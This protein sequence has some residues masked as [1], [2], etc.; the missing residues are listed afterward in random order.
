MAETLEKYIRRY[1]KE[2]ERLSKQKLVGSIKKDF[3][4][5][6]DN[7]I[8]MYLSKLKKE[9]VI[10]APSRGIYEMDSYIPFQPNISNGLKRIFNKVKREFPYINFCIW[11]T[12]WLNDFMLHQP[13]K[14]Y[15]VIEV[16]KGASESVFAFLTETN[17]NVF[18][19]PDEEIFDR[20]IHNQD[21]V[22]IVKNMVSES[23]LIEK[24][25]INVPALEKLLVDMLIDTT[26]FSAQQNEKEFI[27]RSVMQKY[28]LNDLKMRRYAVRRNREREIDELINISLAK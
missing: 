12:V 18:F 11:D 25:K 28:T 23:P 3:P 13:F 22:L 17:K 8:N 1:F 19:N 4:S 7:T 2:S 26:L 14:H 15:V 5:W 21:E 6:S 20:Y 24:D 10:N 27:M 16:E 9:G